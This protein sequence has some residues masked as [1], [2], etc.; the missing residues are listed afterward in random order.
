ML[1]LKYHLLPGRC[2]VPFEAQDFHDRVYLFWKGFWDGVL[3]DLDGTEVSP[4]EFDRQTYIGVI[5]NGEDL[6]AA[7]LYTV[8]S[9][10]SLCARSHS[11]LKSSFEPEFHQWLGQLGSYSVMSVEYL[12]VSPAYRKSKMGFSLAHVIVGLGLEIQKAIKADWTVAICRQDLHVDKIGFQHGATGF[13]PRMMH[14]VPVVSMKLP[15]E[16]IRDC[17]LP[18]ESQMIQKMWSERQDWTNIP[19]IGKPA[20]VKEA[21]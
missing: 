6:V 2:P 7:H 1:D 14:N 17:P 15:L 13:P 12:T 3:K 18:T 4:N 16:D 19:K 9:A 20:L 21:A 10:D 5:T 8:F 11:Y